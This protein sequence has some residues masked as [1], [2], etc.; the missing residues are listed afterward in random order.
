MGF[1]CY[2][3]GEATTLGPILRK[4]AESKWRESTEAETQHKALGLAA[5][6]RAC[7]PGERAGNTELADHGSCRLYKGCCKN[8]G[9]T[10][11]PPFVL[12][13]FFFLQILFGFAC[14]VEAGTN[15]GLWSN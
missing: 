8:K 3:K 6:M 1:P 15:I 9:W 12:F 14:L 2:L 5:E 10:P 4:A 13:F 7:F 11:F